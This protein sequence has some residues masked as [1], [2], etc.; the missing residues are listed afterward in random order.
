MLRRTGDAPRKSLFCHHA[1][2]QTVGVNQTPCCVVLLSEDASSSGARTRAVT[3]WLSHGSSPTR[4]PPALMLDALATDTSLVRGTAS[5]SRCAPAGRRSAMPTAGSPLQLPALPAARLRQRP[6]PPTAAVP[7]GAVS[8]DA[9][10]VAGLCQRAPAW[11]PT[12]SL[13][14]SSEIPGLALRTAAA[15]LC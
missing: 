2:W 11:L 3:W 10:V 6:V 4:L 1:I 13:R 15:V 9:A 7:R 5:P 12:R 8:R 14:N